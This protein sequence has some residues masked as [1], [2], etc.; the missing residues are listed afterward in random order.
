VHVLK[1][2]YINR[3][4]FEVFLRGLIS[5]PK[6]VGSDPEKYW[7]TCNILDIQ[8][9]GNSQHEIRKLFGGI[10]K[11]QLGF[12]IS[13]TA[14]STKANHYIYLDDGLFSGSRFRRDVTDWIKDSGRADCRLDAV[15]MAVHSY[16]VFTAQKALNATITET[17]KDIKLEIWTALTI[18]DRH[19]NLNNSDVLRPISLPVDL[20]VQ[21]Y[22]DSL[23]EKSSYPPSYRIPGQI[24]PAK[25]FS[26]DK[27]RN[28]LEQEFLKAGVQIR[29]SSPNL[30]ESH[31][32]LGYTGL[33]TLGFGSMII[34]FRNCPN[35]AP[36]A[37]W[38][39]TP[40]KPLFP[41]T[42]N[43][44]AAFERLLENI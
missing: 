41:R 31:R 18:E 15:F 36:L 2:T 14:I 13:G 21:A 19:A 43:R 40:W 39:G 38:A 20:A 35:S 24:G 7:R 11:K 16:G 9:G 28:L 4:A 1:K 3:D 12:D 29:A 5:N 30:K 34:T 37:L 17:K 27:G 25:F 8:K 44:D 23:A 6:L 26:G 22:A 10:L 42:T 32:P 33:P